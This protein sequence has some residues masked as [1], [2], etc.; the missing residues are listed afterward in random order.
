MK[1]LT[2]NDILDEMELR[3]PELGT[4]EEMNGGDTV[5]KLCSWYE[6]LRDSLSQEYTDNCCSCGTKFTKETPCCCDQ[7]CNPEFTLHRDGLCVLCCKPIHYHAPHLR[8]E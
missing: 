5:E 6:E 3:F 1:K 7:G 2:I 4:E 8:G